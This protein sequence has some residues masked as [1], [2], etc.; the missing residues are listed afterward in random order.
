MALTP[1]LPETD[2]MLI[3]MPYPLS[4]ELAK[5]EM[6]PVEDTEQVRLD[7]PR[8]IDQ[9]NPPSN[10]L[11]EYAQHSLSVILAIL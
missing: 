2:A 5:G 4:A 1:I 8:T 6:A 10:V 9:R 11:D 7:H 3:K